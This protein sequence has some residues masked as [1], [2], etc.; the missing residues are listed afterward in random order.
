MKEKRTSVVRVGLINFSLRLLG[1]PISFAFSYIV[2][3]Y[4]SRI[5]LT[6]FGLWQSVFVYI[7]GL[8]SIPA[9]SIS[10]VTSKI[11]AEG[12]GVGGLILV[13]LAIGGVSGL[14]YV[15]LQ[16][17]LIPASSNLDPSAVELAVMM[18]L[19]YYLLTSSNAVARGRTPT[20]V[21]VSAITF[22]LV[23]LGFLLYAFFMLKM[24]I[25]GVVL[26]YTLGYL[27]QI[28]VN[29]GF[30]RANFS[31]DRQATIEGLKAAVVL[32]VAYLQ[33]MLEASL[34]WL[35]N[36]LTQSTVPAS[37]FESAM[38]VTNVVF[39]ASSLSDGLIKR[40][41]ES[42]DPSDLTIALKLLASAG[43][44]VLVLDLVGLYPLL[45]YIRPEYTAS[46]VIAVIL[47]LSNFA[48]MAFM[49]YYYALIALDTTLGKSLKGPMGTMLLYNV[50]FA[51]FPLSVVSVVL[52]LVSRGL[53]EVRGLTDQPWFFGLVMA[54]AMLTNSVLMVM[55]AHQVTNRIV[56]VMFP[57]RSFLN[58]AVAVTIAVGPFLPVSFV[59]SISKAIVIELS[60][61][62]L[63]IL[64]SYLIDDYTRLLVVRTLQ[65]IKR[66][67][68]R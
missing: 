7:T 19:V 23:R 54:L 58:A 9:T 67:I 48:R 20:V 49:T 55:N 31:L 24:T 64:V 44:L 26:A 51:V 13:N 27:S 63:Y 8:F 52:L 38:I 28:A 61:G 68:F 16:P 50:V 36:W 39:W 65:E 45:Y 25:L 56:K 22:Q 47:A 35:A 6:L 2:A 43:S 62:L 3:H 33:Y 29:V 10:N 21:G 53:I 30:V 15:L 17:Y 40:F 41:T 11:A 66:V 5:D 59:S 46:L 60:A 37:Y 4:L 57:S 34:V 18:L 1:A 12:R 42:K 32:S 14:A